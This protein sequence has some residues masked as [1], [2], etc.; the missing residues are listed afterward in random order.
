MQTGKD[1]DVPVIISHHKC[2]GIK[3]HGRST[4]TLGRL[5]EAQGTGQ[6]IAP[7]VYPHIA[8]STILSCCR[9]ICAIAPIFW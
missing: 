9:A 1:G 2:V 4:E 8:S 5:A 7:D 3:N 6:Q